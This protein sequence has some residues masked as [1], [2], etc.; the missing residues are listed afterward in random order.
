MQSFS[1]SSDSNSSRLSTNALS[2]LCRTL[3]HINAEQATGVI[4]FPA[5][6]KRSS[7]PDGTS[8]RKDTRLIGH[9]A[10]LYS[11]VK[12]C[13]A[14]YLMS[15]ICPT[16]SR[17]LLVKDATRARI[18]A[19]S[20]E[21][22]IPRYAVSTLLVAELAFS[23]PPFFFFPTAFHSSLLLLSP[24]CGSACQRSFAND[25][26]N[27]AS[28]AVTKSRNNTMR[29]SSE[30]VR[31]VMVCGIGGRGATEGS[32]ATAAGGFAVFGSGPAPTPACALGG[33]DAASVSTTCGAA[34]TAPS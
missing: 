13:P 9:C 7:P 4:F 34:D 2:P 14:W 31:A 5:L 33:L 1:S 25:N 23:E 29:G 17:G 19:T 24:L 12:R 11:F 8:F 30:M 15:V 6:A 20:S 10:P 28:P 32:T 3:D 27:S 18:L 16:F 26:N 21:S 22:F